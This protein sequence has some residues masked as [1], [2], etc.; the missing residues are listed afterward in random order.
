MQTFLTIVS[1]CKELQI[2]ISL[3]ENQIRQF[4]LAAD[5]DNT[6][7]AI[8]L[9]GWEAPTMGS[10]Y[11]YIDHL[12]EVQTG[13]YNEADES[14]LQ[15]DYL[16][17]AVNCFSSEMIAGE[18]ARAD[19]LFRAL[20]RYAVEHRVLPADPQ[21]GGY[22]IMYNYETN[23]LEVAMTGPYRGFGDLVFEREALAQEAINEFR[24]EL[25]W[26]FTEMT[27]KM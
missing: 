16:Y 3:D 9:N 11:F 14:R 25:L 10:A 4:Y 24:T 23:S 5:T 20:R 27:D 7:A 22:T 12:G 18:I 2:P 8:Q 13:Y 17:N 21:A 26:Y 15:A 19:T 1:G 6:A